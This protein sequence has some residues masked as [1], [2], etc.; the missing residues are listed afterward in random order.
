MEKEAEVLKTKLAFPDLV[1]AGGDQQ[2]PLLPMAPMRTKK[3][4]RPRR[5]P[6]APQRLQLGARQR[7]RLRV[8]TSGVAVRGREDQLAASVCFLGAP[9]FHGRQSPRGPWDSLAESLVVRPGSY[10]LPSL[11]PLW[12]FGLGSLPCRSCAV[13]PQEPKL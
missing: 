9:R 6:G 12:S 1:R 7:A 4:T 3:I 5:N 10:S 11:A 13:K 8:S 2:P